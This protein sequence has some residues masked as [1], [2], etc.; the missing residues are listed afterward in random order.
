[1]RATRRRSFAVL[2]ACGVGRCAGMVGSLARAPRVARL[3][4][5]AISIAAIGF[6]EVMVP[7][8]CIRRNKKFHKSIR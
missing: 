3:V 5:A 6:M 2:P 1:M 8:G 4:T 7:G